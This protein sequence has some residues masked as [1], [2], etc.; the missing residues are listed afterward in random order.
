MR[1]NYDRHTAERLVPLLNVITTEM[2]ERA[3][4]VR[5]LTRQ[6]RVL[7]REDAAQNKILDLQ[8]RIST[9]RRELRLSTEELEKLGCY[10][11][12]GSPLAVIIP[13]ADGKHEHG[14][15]WDCGA[16]DL[17]EIDTPELTA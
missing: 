15:R 8:A 11:D 9:H 14:Y 16:L 1:R 13:G 3:E 17:I 7:R 5:T 2:T 12:E 4:A 6:L 10:V